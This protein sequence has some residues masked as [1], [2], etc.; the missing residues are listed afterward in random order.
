MPC[1]RPLTNHRRAIC[2]FAAIREEAPT[3]P[4]DA[5][6]ASRCG[7]GTPLPPPGADSPNKERP[8]LVGLL[9]DC[10]RSRTAARWPAALR[11]C[12]AADR[13]WSPL[14]HDPAPPARPL[15]QRVWRILP[16]SRGEVSV[17]PGQ[18]VTCFTGYLVCV[19]SH[20]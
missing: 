7:S 10:P 13:S 16:G 4:A 15:A 9:A 20:L 19:S 17:L 3:A 8:L 18:V 1:T 5:A 14:P 2:G 12:R 11:P 6:C